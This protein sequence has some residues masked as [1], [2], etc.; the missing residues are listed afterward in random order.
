MRQKKVCIQYEQFMISWLFNILFTSICLNIT[1]QASNHRFKKG[2]R[3]NYE[4]FLYFTWIYILY[5]YTVLYNRK[6]LFFFIL[7]YA[8]WRKCWLF[9]AESQTSYV[10]FRLIFLFTRG[11]S[12]DLK[13]TRFTAVLMG[14]A[15]TFYLILSTESWKLRLSSELPADPFFITQF[16]SF[17]IFFT[18]FINLGNL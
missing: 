2:W 4:V 16:F 15:Q 5:L 7:L 3:V 10:I 18:F 11:M 14:L 12:L 13:I 8:T 17:F 9:G 6:A 1:K